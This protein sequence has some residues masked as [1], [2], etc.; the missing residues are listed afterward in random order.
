MREMRFYPE[1]AQ[2]TKFSFQ[3][4][5]ANGNQIIKVNFV[6]GWFKGTSQVRTPGTWA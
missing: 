3:D 5:A 4:A 1:K 2:V 6:K